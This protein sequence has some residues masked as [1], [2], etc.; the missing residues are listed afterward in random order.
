MSYAEIL[1]PARPRFAPPTMTLR[2][3]HE[4]AGTLSF[5]S[6]MPGTSYGLPAT[7]CKAGARLANI[8]GSVCATC[9]ALKDFYTLPNVER[10]QR[11]RLTSVAHPRWVDAMVCLLLHT[12]ASP[13]IPVDRGVVG[14]RAGQRRGFNEAGWHRWHDSGDIQSVEHLAKIV[15]VCRRTPRIKHW[16]PTREARMVREFLASNSVPKNLVIRMS[17]TMVDGP[18]PS[19]ATTSGVHTT[20]P[21]DGAY[22]CPAPTQGHKCGSCRAC[23]SL[24]VAAVSYEAH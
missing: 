10:A 12:H 16:L 2:E 4:I 19:F 5:P 18:L 9:Y 17:A 15:E 8:K 23:W 11:R 24:S 7:A 21:A 14:I 3:A 22:R 20:A 13:L 6:K 1:A